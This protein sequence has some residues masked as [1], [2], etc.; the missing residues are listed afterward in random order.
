MPSK[1]SVLSDP[2][3]LSRFESYGPADLGTLGID[4]FFA[5]HKCN[6]Y[7]NPRWTKPARLPRPAQIPMRQG[8]TMTRQRPGRQ[9]LSAVV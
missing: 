5:R 1:N 2:A 8:T 3:I 9:V 7:C 4:A 6:Q